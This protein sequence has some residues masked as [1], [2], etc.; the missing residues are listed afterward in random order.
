MSNL[1]VISNLEMLQHCK[2]SLWSKVYLARVEDWVLRLAY[3]VDTSTGLMYSMMTIVYNTELNVGNLTDLWQQTLSAAGLASPKGRCSP[4]LCPAPWPSHTGSGWCSANW[5]WAGAIYYPAAIWRNCWRSTS[6][7]PR[8][9]GSAQGCR[10]QH[11]SGSSRRNTCPG[12]RSNGASS[13]TLWSTQGM[14][15]NQLTLKSTLWPYFQFHARLNVDCWL[16]AAKA[17]LNLIAAGK[18]WR[19]GLEALTFGHSCTLLVWNRCRKHRTFPTYCWIWKK[20]GV[21]CS[22][23]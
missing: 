13:Q 5:K 21:N 18:A 23:T 10:T 6:W 11:K 22:E 9:W 16:H 20:G 12:I 14:S 1:N 3:R 17:I 2:T 15:T 4:S 7:S 19:Q 8:R